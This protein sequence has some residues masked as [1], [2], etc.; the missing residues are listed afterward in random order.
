MNDV[1]Q[2]EDSM[3]VRVGQIME[4]KLPEQSLSTFPSRFRPQPTQRLFRD[5][6][7]TSG[8]R[9]TCENFNVGLQ[10]ASG[11]FGIDVE[12]SF[13]PTGSSLSRDSQ[14]S[15]ASSLDS[16]VNVGSERMNLTSHATDLSI[17]ASHASF[18]RYESLDPPIVALDNSELQ[19]QPQSLSEIIQAIYEH[20]PTEIRRLQLPEQRRPRA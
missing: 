14:L 19:S 2:L 10:M 6:F 9:L 3:W 13:L 16:L 4:D 12:T 18:L 5:N 1:Q 15:Q 11:S 8:Q 7:D 17:I 20:F